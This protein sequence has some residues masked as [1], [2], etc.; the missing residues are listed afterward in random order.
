MSNI[1]RHKMAFKYSQ[2]LDALSGE[3]DMFFG[4]GPADQSQSN[5]PVYASMLSE[6]AKGVGG[7]LQDQQAKDTAAK[8]AAADKEANKEGDAAVKLAQDL[9]KKASLAAIDAKTAK[10]RSDANP[11]DTSLKAAAKRAQD[12]YVSL[13]VDAT[14]AEAKA[15]YYKP[16]FGQPPAP[17]QAQQQAMQQQQQAQKSGGVFTTKNM[18]IGGG[19]VIGVGGLA[20]LLYKLLS[21]RS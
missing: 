18:L 19:V 10:A 9:R 8:Q 15:A 2:G 3:D 20:A 4:D 17:S 14:A 5:A 16:G 11:T 21:R 7:A 12:L 1:R 13:D 6:V